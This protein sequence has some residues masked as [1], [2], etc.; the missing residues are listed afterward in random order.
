[1]L[2]NVLPSNSGTE[3]GNGTYNLHAIAHGNDGQSTDMG[4]R[5]IVVN[6]ATAVLP[7]GTIDTPTQGATVSGTIVNFGWALT[8]QPNIIPIDGSTITV[9]ID[10]LP[11]GHPTYNQPRSDIEMLFPGY[12]N[13]D[14]AVG[15]FYVETTTLTNGVHTIAWVVRDT[16]GNAQ[17]LGS[18][19]F[20]VQN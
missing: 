15:Y 9:F 14:G 19:Y 7:F 20:T 11:V 8:P 16:A 18:R 1:M 2:T 6:N 4:T 12:Q 10:N 5:T 13:T 3:I 17:G